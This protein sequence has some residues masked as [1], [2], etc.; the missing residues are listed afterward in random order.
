MHIDNHAF[1]IN[2]LD[3]HHLVIGND[4]GIAISRDR[5]E[6]WR[7]VR[8]LPLAQFYHIRVDKEHPY[9]VYGGLQDNGSWRGPAE[10]WIPAGIRNLHWQEVGFGDG[11]DTL[12]D[13]ENARAGY[14]MSQGGFLSR[15]NLDTGEQRLIRPAPHG[16]DVDL[17]FNWNAGIAQDP[18]EPATIYF[19]SQYLHKS[20][21]RGDTWSVI[22]KDLTTNDP[23]MQTF[24]ASGGLTSDV[25]AA[26]NY[27]TIVTIAASELQQ[28]L[29]WVGSDDGRI[30]VTRDGGEGWERIDERARGVTAGAWV[31]MITPSPHDAGTAF[32]VFDDHRRSNMETYVYRVENYGRKWTRLSNDGVSGYALSVLQDFVDP[33]L[34]FLGTEFG[35]FVS[36]DGGEGWTKFTAGVPTVSV[37]DMA[38]QQRETDLVLGTH[39]RSVFVIDDYSGL[40][41]LSEADFDTRLRILSTTTGQHY[42]TNPTSSS[43][44]AGSGEFRGENEPRGV[45][46]TFMASGNDLP[47][48]EEDAERARKIARR[49]AGEPSDG[50]NGN[51]NGEA[52]K[53]TVSVSNASGEL[54][55]TFKQPVHQGINRIA[56]DMRVDGVR[57]PPGP[58]REEPE[59]G[60]PAGPEV[61]PGDFSVTLKLD[62]A[63]DS[64]DVNTV[65]DP[66]SAY[67]Q[68]DFEARF[69]AE[70]K[71][72][73]LEETSVSALEQIDRAR[74]DVVTI[75]KLIG[76]QSEADSDDGFKALK[77]QAKEVKKG[78][79]ELEKRLRN[80]PETKGIVYSADKT[81]SKIDMAQ[82]Y[83]GSG[84]GAPTAT[85][86]AYVDTARMA[87]ED[88]LSAVNE[89]MNNELAAFRDAVAVAGIG[90]LQAPEPVAISE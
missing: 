19:G 63:E 56:W 1:W 51:G 42:E 24:R 75:T 21:D 11:F 66:R 78:L 70:I 86:A 52:P 47:H 10:I 40:R 23:D 31:P 27:T 5:G 74:N 55:R 69:A 58:K 25:T 32:V 15:Y 46:I 89:Y 73:K 39:G 80:L 68:S 18:F 38:I 79:D 3:P 88:S 67:G 82:Y 57:P 30:H 45:L 48:P 85:A 83:V 81:V 33:E 14:A 4:G 7:F 36:V 20:T 13:P 35:L 53:V 64:A 34:L 44:F 9:N 50:E 76:Q 49:Q 59:D 62:D 8:N 26:E 71:L 65:A 77:E 29:L 72:Q 22:S 90:L 28:G 16:P 37:M 87:M 43:R 17:R 6:T 2:P 84:T 41:N 54:I 61:A 60:L 12:P